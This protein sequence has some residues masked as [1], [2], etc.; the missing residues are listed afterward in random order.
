MLLGHGI[1]AVGTGSIK[2]ML[3]KGTKCISTSRSGSCVGK[4]GNVPETTGTYDTVG[5]DTLEYFETSSAKVGEVFTRDGIEYVV[6][7][8]DYVQGDAA[9]PSSTSF[10]AVPTEVLRAEGLRVL[11]DTKTE[12]WP[13]PNREVTGEDRKND[14]VYDALMGVAMKLG[15]RYDEPHP[16]TVVREGREAIIREFWRQRGEAQYAI[17]EWRKGFSSSCSAD[18]DLV[19]CN[20]YLREFGEVVPPMREWPEHVATERM[21]MQ[22]L[23]N[24]RACGGESQALYFTATLRHVTGPIKE[25]VS[26]PWATRQWFDDEVTDL[27]YINN[28]RK[29]IKTYLPEVR[30][31]KKT[32]REDI[33]IVSLFKD[34]L[35][36]STPAGFEDCLDT[37][38]KTL[39]VYT[40]AVQNAERRLALMEARESLVRA[41][42]VATAK[43]P[44]IGDKEEAMQRLGAG[45]V[46]GARK[47]RFT[48]PLTLLFPGTTREEVEEFAVFFDYPG[49]IAL[50]GILP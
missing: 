5:W 9:V 38:I 2:K 21:V 32:L 44:Q 24:I 6:V 11:I 29:A 27:E 1:I 22:S 12:V 16:V 26:D 20:G 34:G 15:G 37:G 48:E 49:S 13:S 19:V 43:I 18:N 31:R 45:K 8:N 30:T 42:G 14:K 36:D 17:A 50:A 39:S 33:L 35:L 4:G 28:E 7:K 47:E 10:C 41:A 40:E 23:K 25:K 3:P 46:L